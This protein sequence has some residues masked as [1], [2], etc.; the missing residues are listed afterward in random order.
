M[1]TPLRGALAALALSF[2]VA[3]SAAAQ[4][5]P[6]LGQYLSTTGT[7]APLIKNGQVDMDLMGDVSRHHTV[8]ISATPFTEYRSDVLFMLETLHPGIVL[9]AYTQPQ[10][11]Y[12]ASQPDSNVHIPTR[13]RRMVR[14]LN[15][16]LYDR[17]GQE[18]P[19]ATVNLAKRQG[20]RYVVAEA[21]ADFYWLNILQGRQWDGMFLDR[22]CNSILWDQAPGDSIDIARA[23]YSSAAAFDAA[24]LAG[25]DTLAN[26]LRRLAGSKPI[27]VGN[28]ATGNKYASMNGWMRENFPHQNG[29]SWES[30]MNRDPGGYFIDDQRF[31]APHCNWLTAWPVPTESPYS[32]ENLRRARF[33]LGTAALGE[34]LGVINPPD[35][36]AST[37]Y[38]RWWYDEYGVTVST[39]VATK[40]LAA[41][42]WLGQP[43]GPR[44]TQ[45]WV[46]DGEEAIV[47]PGF[48]TDVTTGWLFSSTAGAS[49]TRDT[50]SPPVGVA[51]ARATIPS[52][53]AGPSSTKVRSLGSLFY[54]PPLPHSVTF[55]AR[56]AAPRTIQVAA[57]SV[58]NPIDFATST[59]S[60]DAT[61]RQY[62]VI[63]TSG[64]GFGPVLLEFRLGGSATNVWLDD[65]H[66][67]REASS[68]H[69]RDFQNGIVLVNPS[70]TPL[71]VPLEAPFRRIA[72]TV[73]PA[74]NDGMWTT[75]AVVNANDALFLVRQ[76]ASTVAVDPPAARGAAPLWRE[77]VPNPARGPVRALIDAS[78]AGEGPLEVDVLDVRGRLIA[79]LLRSDRHDAMTAIVWD[80]RDMHG[81]I[82]P[83]GLYWLR[84]RIGERVESKKI[85]RLGDGS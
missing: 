70:A 35:L 13:L 23:G 28:C 33:T 44:W 3:A 12:P 34:G 15:G 55:W 67:Q 30:N 1:R 77:V 38:W 2:L 29:G 79:V 75:E 59:V 42:G 71:F 18:F 36:D 74:V 78:Y 54:L 39:G 60:I 26:R 76:S 65:V 83:S 7:G 52:A 40:S 10:Y 85:L 37:N 41:T 46:G 43:L 56:A 57:V 27:L 6:R 5:Y 80:G 61:W 21:L 19:T 69:R 82:M 49:W 25:T 17:T 73:D 63:W 45:F 24:W 50:V 72:G 11:I 58:A 9:L 64:E 8:V 14:D 66:F 47:N 16:Y 31:R 20:N 68:I 4:N 53:G 84:A 48:D 81:R 62:Q 32:T 51:S 22:F